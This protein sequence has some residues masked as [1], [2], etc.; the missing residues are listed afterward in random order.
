MLRSHNAYPSGVSAQLD[1]M[2]RAGGMGQSRC[3]Q[4]VTPCNTPC[5]VT[6][7]LHNSYAPFAECPG[8]RVLGYRAH[9]SDGIAQANQHLHYRIG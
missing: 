6:W 2:L 1:I 4:D 7:A 9:F 8:P 5:N 3:W